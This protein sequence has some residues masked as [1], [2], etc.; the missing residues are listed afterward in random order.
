VASGQTRT[1]LTGNTREVMAVA[2]SPDG[3]TLATGSVDHS[4]RLWDVASGQTRATLVGHA[5]HVSSVAFSPDGRTLATGSAD[6]TARLWDVAL[7][8]PASAIEKIC[9]A[10]NRDLTTQERTLYLPAS[11]SSTAVCG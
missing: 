8:T 1:T 3:R 5:S 10:V 7:P 9:R 6:K 2:F 11:Q 4:T